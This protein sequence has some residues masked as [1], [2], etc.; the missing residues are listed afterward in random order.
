MTLKKDNLQI[1]ITN[2]TKVK[3][4]KKYFQKIGEIVL[5]KLKQSKGVKVSLVFV[6][7]AEMRKLNKKYRG[8]D[9]TTD[10]LSFN[11]Q[12]GKSASSFGEI[13]ISISQAKKQA[14]K[15][16]YPLKCELSE[17]F[18]HGILHLVGYEDEEDKD[19]ERT[20]KK[21]KEILHSL[22]QR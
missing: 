21:Q 3:I 12:D 2:L 18:V 16:S 5:R 14:T 4:D 8:M 13:V 22:A 15:R 10:V 1:D 9:K 20:M 19:Y 6:N 11:Y 7:D 17:L